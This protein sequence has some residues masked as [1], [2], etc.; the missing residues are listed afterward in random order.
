M[1]GKM[2]KNKR[3]EEDGF[4]VKNI[5]RDWNCDCAPQRGGRLKSVHDVVY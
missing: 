5:Y 3:W 1:R 2:M 4:L